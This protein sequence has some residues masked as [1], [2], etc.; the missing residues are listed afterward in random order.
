MNRGY[1]NCRA[2]ARRT[3]CKYP[4]KGWLYKC[5]QKSENA[6]NKVR[7]E[8]ILWEVG[9]IPSLNIPLLRKACSK[10]GKVEW[11][12]EMRAEYEEANQLMLTQIKLSPYNPEKS[13]YLVVDGASKIGTGFCLL[14]SI[15]TILRSGDQSDIWYLIAQDCQ[16]ICAKYHGAC[17]ALQFLSKAHFRGLQHSL[18]CFVAT[19]QIS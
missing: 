15:I 4:T 3:G 10:N 6:R 9:I 7:S 11:N 2:S 14:Q 16:K 8:V 5:F 12:Q 13:L 1:L 18:R 19:L 17:S